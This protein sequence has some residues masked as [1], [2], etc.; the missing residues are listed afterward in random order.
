M[1]PSSALFDQYDADYCSRATGVAGRID[2]L[3]GLSG[4]T[5]G[6][7]R[8]RE[9]EGG[10]G[11]KTK[12][13]WGGQGRGGPFVLFIPRTSL[14]LLHTESRL[15]AARAIA[16][17][18]AECDALIG[19]LELEARA[20][21]PAGAG[22]GAAASARLAKARQYKA[23]AA[24]LRAKAARAGAAGGGGGG[25][26]TDA[27]AGAD[28]AARAEL[29]LAGGGGGG[30]GWGGAPGG[31]NL[32]APGGA[33]RD[34]V[35]STTARLERTGDRLAQ[36]RAQ[37]LQTEVRKMRKEEWVFCMER[38]EGEATP[39]PN[40]PSVVGGG[41]GGGGGDGRHRATPSSSSP[42][43]T[44]LFLGRGGERGGRWWWK[45]AARGGGRPL[46]HTSPLTLFSIPPPPPLFFGKRPSAPTSSPAWP[47]SG[48]HW[49]VP[50]LP[51]QRRMHPPPSPA[52]YSR[53]WGSGGRFRRPSQVLVSRFD[54]PSPLRGRV[55]F[56]SLIIISLYQELGVSILSDLHRQRETIAHAHD[57]LHGTD[58]ALASARR[59]LGTM[60]RRASA[61]KAIAGAVIAVLTAAVL[62][63]LWAKV[64]RSM[65]V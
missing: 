10:R 2:A 25:V 23:D 53:R 28:A 57:T 44:L 12:K 34:A 36:G 29:G 65:N 31:A 56:L 32:A 43:T 62:L 21:T 40:H 54:T 30:G 6:R 20:A 52:P 42:S 58:D 19:R 50:G 17:D 22:G 26:G 63:V 14:S 60:S 33:H 24:A 5:K 3:A 61:N 18:L 4:G 1:D 64:F 16:A 8:E 48:P 59:L 49:S 38:E 46:P 37:L 45:W 41:G 47:N 15:Q 9:G 27:S 39:T 51:C 7:G 13:R 55:A 35:L 11:W